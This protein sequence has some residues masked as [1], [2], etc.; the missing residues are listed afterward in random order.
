MRRDLLLALFYDINVEKERDDRNC[1]DVG[2]KNEYKEERSD[3]RTEVH[4]TREREREKRLRQE[5]C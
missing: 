2:S 4:T 3:V 5:A 1:C